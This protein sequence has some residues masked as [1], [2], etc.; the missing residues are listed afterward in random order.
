MTTRC[1]ESAACPGPRVRR[2]TSSALIKSPSMLSPAEIASTRCSRPRA[3]GETASCNGESI[4]RTSS[5][6]HRVS[7]AAPGIRYRPSDS[8]TLLPTTRSSRE[9]STP[10][11]SRSSRKVPGSAAPSAAA[12]ADCTSVSRYLTR[13]FAASPLVSSPG[14]SSSLSPSVAIIP[15]FGIP[16]RLVA[17]GTVPPRSSSLVARGAS[18]DAPSSIGGHRLVAGRPLRSRWASG[19]AP[20]RGHR[21]TR[22][23]IRFGLLRK[24]A[25]NGCGWRGRPLDVR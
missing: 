18:G 5:I 16:P 3:S 2:A 9:S 25:R 15:S 1:S 13:S 10:H 22:R 19:A 12:R 8:W 7:L 23:Q 6:A 24:Q 17:V 14:S 20:G 11:A 4:A 21:S